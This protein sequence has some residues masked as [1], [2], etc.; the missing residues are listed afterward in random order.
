MKFSF[1]VCLHVNFVRV[2]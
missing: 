1:V 2:L